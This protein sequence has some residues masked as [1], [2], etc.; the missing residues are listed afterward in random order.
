MKQSDDVTEFVRRDVENV[1]SVLAPLAAAIK[2]KSAIPED[3]IEAEQF[4]AAV[5]DVRVCNGAAATCFAKEDGIDAIVRDMLGADVAEITSAAPERPIFRAL[6]DRMAGRPP[7]YVSIRRV[8]VVAIGIRL[9][10]RTQQRIRL[11][12]TNQDERKQEDKANDELFHFSGSFC[13]LR[14]RCFISE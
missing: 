3:H 9:S 4:V 11:H 7:P 10:F 13:T 6:A 14:I 2:L 12:R 8:N 1:D 5:I